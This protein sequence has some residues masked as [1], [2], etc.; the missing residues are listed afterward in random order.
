MNQ[1]QRCQPFK[2]RIVFFSGCVNCEDTLSQE[3]S[4]LNKNP[5]TLPAWRKTRARKGK[6]H[7][8]QPK[9]RKCCVH[10]SGQ[11][12]LLSHLRASCVHLRGLRATCVQPA[13]N[14]RAPAWPACNLRATCVQPA[15]TCVACVHFSAPS[16]RGFPCLRGNFSEF[17]VC[18]SV[19]GYFWVGGWAGEPSWG[20][21]E[22][23]P[24]SHKNLCCPA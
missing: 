7:Q 11:N 9:A 21:L 1:D 3:E 16:F 20:I 8:K 19:F 10:C 14:L 23:N 4:V 18:V 5:H 12:S 24:M 22:N 2:H 15:C 13:C 6:P 17:C